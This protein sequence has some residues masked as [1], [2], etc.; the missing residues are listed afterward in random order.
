MIPAA[1]ALTFLTVVFPK[2]DPYWIK[3]MHL[4]MIV[5]LGFFALFSWNQ[6]QDKVMK[7]WRNIIAAGFFFTL[8]GTA[9][10]YVDSYQNFLFLAALKYWFIA[11]AYGFEIT[12]KYV[13]DYGDAYRYLRDL[14][15]ITALVFISGLF[16]QTEIV[17]GGALVSIALIQAVSIL[18]ASKMDHN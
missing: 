17:I 3:H 2:L 7:T 15:A 5:F 14:S 4:F 16:V 8:I 1:W 18:I 12:S 10:F 6:M 9:G 11:P 13:E